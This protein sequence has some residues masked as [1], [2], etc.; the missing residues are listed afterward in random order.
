MRIAV[1]SDVHG[2]LT[3]LLAVL[4]QIHRSGRF[5]AIVCAGDLVNKGPAAEGVIAAVRSAGCTVLQGNHEQLVSAPEQ[6][7]P[8]LPTAPDERA[9]LLRQAAWTRSRLA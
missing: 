3:A 2:N 7:E 6:A 9:L 5:D 8:Y 1:F 4:D